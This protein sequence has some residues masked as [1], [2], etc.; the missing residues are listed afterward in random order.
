[1]SIWTG[2]DTNLVY[3]IIMCILCFI[4]AGLR[5]LDWQRGLSNLL[6]ILS[7]DNS[8]TGD[9]KTTIT[10]IK[11]FFKYS[12]LVTQALL[13]TLTSLAASVILILLLICGDVESNPGP[14]RYPGE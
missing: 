6:K 5:L 10:K 9:E 1:M 12:V 13:D 4:L 11:D 8:S 7:M 14:G 2:R 3:Y